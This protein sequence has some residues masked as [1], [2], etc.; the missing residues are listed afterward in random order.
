MDWVCKQSLVD[1][2]ALVICLIEFGIRCFAEIQGYL[3]SCLSLLIRHSS[4]C[5]GTFAINLGRMF[6]CLHPLLFGC[7]EP[8]IV[9]GSSVVLLEPG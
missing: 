3:E 8:C 7:F 9:R 6:C 5:C 2:G 1:L 4:S